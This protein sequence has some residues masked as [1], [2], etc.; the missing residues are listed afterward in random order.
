MTAALKKTPCRGVF[1]VSENRQRVAAGQID[2]VD[3]MW[4]KT[5]KNC[6]FSAGKRGIENLNEIIH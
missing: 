6:L 2:S 4:I 5:R 3:N 1:F